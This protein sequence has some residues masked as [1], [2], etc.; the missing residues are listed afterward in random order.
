MRTF[1]YLYEACRWGDVT[2]SPSDQ[3]W[4]SCLCQALL[5]CLCCQWKQ[6]VLSEGGEKKQKKKPKHNHLLFRNILQIYHSKGW[7]AKVPGVFVAENDAVLT[8]LGFNPLAVG[9]CGVLEATQGD[10]RAGVFT[11]DLLYSLSWVASENLYVDRFSVLQILP[12]ICEKGISKINCM[13]LLNHLEY[14]HGFGLF[15]KETIC[16]LFLRCQNHFMSYCYWV[17][18]LWTH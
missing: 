15:W 7:K 16:S 2:D 3:S 12:K 14:M 13:L 1:L 6:M 11:S 5:K 18:E 17:I 4:V 9:F 10:M 8:L